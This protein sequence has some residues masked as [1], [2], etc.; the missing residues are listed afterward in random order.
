MIALALAAAVALPC[1]PPT[2]GAWTYSQPQYPHLGER[3]TLLP[4]MR[5]STSIGHEALRVAKHGTILTLSLPNGARFE[6]RRLGPAISGIWIEPETRFDHERAFRTTLTRNGSG[7]AG[8]VGPD[9]E[10]LTLNAWLSSSDGKPQLLVRNPD[11]LVGDTRFGAVTDGCGYALTDLNDK[12]HQAKL[13]FVGGSARLNGLSG[14]L[15]I[16]SLTAKAPHADAAAGSGV[17]AAAAD[18]EGLD[19]A[20]LQALMDKV[21]ANDPTAR[22]APLI[23]SILVARRGRLVAERYFAGYSADRLHEMRSLSKS[24]ASLLAGA[25]IAHHVPVS[26][27]T[28]L[29]RALPQYHA[30]FAADPRKGQIT[31]GDLLGMRSGLACDDF[32]D[33]SPGGEDRMQAQT[34]EADWYHYFLAL[35]VIHPR[36]EHYAYCSAGTHVAAGVVAALAHRGALALFEEWIAGPLGITDYSMPL[37]REGRAY[38]GGGAH[39]RP[40][41]LIEVGE[42]VLNGGRWNGRRVVDAEWLKQATGCPASD[43]NCEEGLGWHFNRIAANGRSYREIEANGN[44]GQLLMMFPELDLVVVFTAANFNAYPIWRKFRE[45]LTPQYV[46]A[47]VRK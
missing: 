47:A 21:A 34:E 29:A 9:E 23:H 43:P 44:G 26:A 6:G 28:T 7:W 12:D 13:T 31:L 35:P 17:D 15:P 1:L 40:R 14:K 2:T 25:A 33:G 32:D 5:R 38:F 20:L 30:L 39:M 11:G 19:P 22:G 8:V 42:L 45:E 41:D 37:D 46:L 4:K 10:K 3:L 16:I 36:G 24:F 27:D 18:A